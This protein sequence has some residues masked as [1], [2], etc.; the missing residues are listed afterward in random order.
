MLASPAVLLAAPSLMDMGTWVPA[1]FRAQ[2]KK[3]LKEAFFLLDSTE[4]FLLDFWALG[5]LARALKLFAIG[6]HLT[7]ASFRGAP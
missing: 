7:M 1:F 2:R 5:I 3:S 4:A 6:L